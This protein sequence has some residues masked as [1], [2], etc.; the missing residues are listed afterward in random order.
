MLPDVRMNK[1]AVGLASTR[2][3]LRPNRSELSSRVGMRAAA[4]PHAA[5]EIALHLVI[6]SAKEM[7][8]EADPKLWLAPGTVLSVSPHGVR[9]I[10]LGDGRTRHEFPDGRITLDGTSRFGQPVHRVRKP[11]GTESWQIDYPAVMANM[12]ADLNGVDRNGPS[13]VDALCSVQGQAVHYPAGTRG[14]EVTRLE[15]AGRR[16]F[17]LIS[18]GPMS[19]EE[20]EN[21][22]AAI[23]AAPPRTFNDVALIF[24]LGELGESRDEKQRVVGSVAGFAQYQSK[25]LFFARDRLSTPASARGTMW[26]EAGHL[27]D[28]AQ[29]ASETLQDDSHVPIFGYGRLIV[30]DNKVALDASDFITHYASTNEQEDFAENHRAALELREHYNQ[31]HPGHDFFTLSLDDVQRELTDG[32]YSPGIRRRMG[33]IVRIYQA[34][35]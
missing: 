35:E 2:T 32:G 33:S 9:K 8:I 5:D 26:H 20:L 17:H 13:R 25:C 22:A 1:T 30:D 4:P 23:A 34:P 11:D 21:M 14:N 28:R 6:P 12:H 24:V 19:S 7:E 3:E 10:D 18:D 16:S 29:R 31:S 15:I 27:V